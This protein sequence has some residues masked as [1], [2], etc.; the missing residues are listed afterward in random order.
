LLENNVSDP[1]TTGYLD[2]GIEPLRQI[3]YEMQRIANETVQYQ[4]DRNAAKAAGLVSYSDYLQGKKPAMDILEE[5]R[6][7]R[8][9]RRLSPNLQP[10][11]ISKEKLQRQSSLSTR[12]S[13]SST[14]S[15]TSHNNSKKSNFSNSSKSSRRK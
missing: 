13:F 3:V 6:E 15:S 9:S 2:L 11:K 4:F 5:E 10:I 7:N 14:S 8:A 1:E 12:S